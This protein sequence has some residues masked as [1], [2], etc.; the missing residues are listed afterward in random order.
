MNEKRVRVNGL[1]EFA[2]YYNKNTDMILD[3]I[4]RNLDETKRNFF[5]LRSR[6]DKKVCR[7]TIGVLLIGAGVLLLNKKVE[8]LEKRIQELEDKQVVED[9]YKDDSFDADIKLWEPKD[10]PKPEDDLK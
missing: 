2:H 9:F 8:K 3:K 4:D 1:A 6:V 7:N 5:R 10:E